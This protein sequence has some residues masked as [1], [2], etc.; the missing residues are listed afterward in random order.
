LIIGFIKENA[1]ACHKSLFLNQL[2]GLEKVKEFHK[3]GDALLLKTFFTSPH[4]S[5]FAYHAFPSEAEEL[6]IA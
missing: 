4:Q 3:N 6:L 1:S 2:H 5:Y